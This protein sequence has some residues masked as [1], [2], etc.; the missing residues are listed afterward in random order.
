MTI[1]SFNKIWCLHC[2]ED[3]DRYETSIKEFKKVN[4]Y[5]KVEYRLTTKH[6][7]INLL[8]SYNKTEPGWNSISNDSN[9]HCTREHYTMIKIAYE[10]NYDYIL[11][12]EDDVKL[13]NK[14]NWDLFMN[15]IPDDFDLIRYSCIIDF[16]CPEEYIN[17]Y[18]NNILYSK[19]KYNIWSTGAYALSRKGMKYYIDYINNLHYTCNADIPFFFAPNTKEINSY[20]S[21]IPISYFYN[22]FESILGHDNNYYNKYY[23]N[24]DLSLY[25]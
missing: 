9:Y 25:T 13:L 20:I 3:K 7:S 22:E 8:S 2:I 12:F 6:Q 1:E 19:L 21:S 24:I 11:I 16:P 14:K 23:S 18:Y 17:N 4:I 10:L 5:N 15:N